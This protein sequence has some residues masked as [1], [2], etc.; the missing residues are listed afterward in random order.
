MCQV[1]GGVEYR[2]LGNSSFNHNPGASVEQ[3]ASEMDLMWYVWVEVKLGFQLMSR[4]LTR[5]QCSLAAPWSSA[6]TKGTYLSFVPR[7]LAEASCRSGESAHLLGVSDWSSGPGGSSRSPSSI[8]APDNL[9]CLQA[10]EDP[11]P[12]ER[13]TALLALA[14]PTARMAS[15]P[16]AARSSQKTA[17]SLIQQ[18][19][20]FLSDVAITRTGKPVIRVQGGR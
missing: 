16:T 5:L 6:Q 13:A 4:C 17:R 18:Q 3:L 12:I 11:T 8:E 20:R 1:A 9:E 14:H 7:H 10:D 2:E 15:L 19:R